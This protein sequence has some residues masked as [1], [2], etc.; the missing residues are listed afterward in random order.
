MT[1]KSNKNEIST[2]FFANFG[3][4]LVKV[5]KFDPILKKYERN[6]HP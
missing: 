1:L 6:D 3:L 4:G 5:D 2:I